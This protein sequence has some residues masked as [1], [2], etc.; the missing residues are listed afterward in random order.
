M[1]ERPERS[2]SARPPSGSVM[3]GLMRRA[4]HVDQFERAAAEI[5]DD[6]V[7]PVE[8][9]DHAERGQLGLALAGQH[10]DLGAA[11]PLGRGDEV[12]AVPASRQAAVASTHSRCDL[13]GVAQRAEALERVERLLDRVGGSRP[14]D[15]TSRPRPAST[16]SLK[17]GVGLRVR[18]S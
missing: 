7:R 18:P 12:R 3:P 13:H 14:V 2:C 11:D 16:F 15:C 8:A 1:I 10:L 9:G 4:V 5:A 6:A 17:I